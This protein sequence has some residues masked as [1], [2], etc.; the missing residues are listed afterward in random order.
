VRVCNVL[1][2]SDLGIPTS[3]NRNI[4]VVVGDGSAFLFDDRGVW[5]LAAGHYTEIE[6]VWPCE[7]K[8]ANSHYQATLEPCPSM[9]PTYLEKFLSQTKSITVEMK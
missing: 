1:V 8:K 5:M 4:A 3:Y 7:D 2:G 9:P 6:Q